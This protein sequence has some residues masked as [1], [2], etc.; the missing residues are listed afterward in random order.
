MFYF[1]KCF[2]FYYH[3]MA[4]L[5]LDYT[6]F[7]IIKSLKCPTDAE[8]LVAIRNMH[9]IKEFACLR[10]LIFFFAWRKIEKLVWSASQSNSHPHS[11]I[12]GLVPRATLPLQLSGSDLIKFLPLCQLVQWIFIWSWPEARLAILLLMK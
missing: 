6:C 9:L 7:Y 3:I 11:F 10:P 4:L 2:Y 5:K 8:I 1:I 12:K